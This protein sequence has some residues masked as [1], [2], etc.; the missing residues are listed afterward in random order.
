MIAV[1]KQKSPANIAIL[2]IFGLL[3]KLPIFSNPIPIVATRNDGHLY[4]WIVSFLSG[5]SVISA[6]LAYFF[7]YIQALMVN[8]LVNEYR[9]MARYNYLPAMAYMIITSLLPQWNY[10]SSPM[11]ANTFIIWMFIYLFSLYNA[12]NTRAQVFNIGFIAGISSYIYFPSAAFVICI[13][14]GLMILKPFRINELILFV[15]G[16]LTPYY[17]HAVYLFLTD[18]LSAFNFFPHITVSVPVVKSSLWLAE[19]TVLLTIPFLMGGYY[20]QTHLRKM[21]I[22]V[23]K[24]WSVLLLYLILA[25]F[26]PFINSDQAFHTWILVVPPFAA[27]HGCA[28]FYPPRRWFPLMLFCITVGYILVQQYSMNTWK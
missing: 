22:Q 8:Y 7:L 15:L 13:L 20:I 1:F 18:R 14:L 6:A 26:V 9:M 16:C 5:H 27:F 21:L 24:N 28:Y 12:P 19:S 3:L 4:Q 25:F 11:M 2:F 17:F 10:L 23:R